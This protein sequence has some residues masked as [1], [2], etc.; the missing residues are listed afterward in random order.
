[1]YIKS[2]QKIFSGSLAFSLIIGFL[3]IHADAK[4]IHQ[5]TSGNF[6]LPGII[7][8]PTAKSFPDGELVITQQFTIFGAFSIASTASL[9]SLFSTEL[10]GEAYGRVNHDRNFDLHINI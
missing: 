8:L 1:M 4:S 6:G 5:A 9:V 3:S 7:D 2:N 10:T